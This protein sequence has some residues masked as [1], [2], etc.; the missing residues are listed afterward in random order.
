[1]LQVSNLNRLFLEHVSFDLARGERVALLGT[2]GSGKSLLLRAIADL[3]PNEGEVSLDG[4]PRASMPAPEW[5]HAVSYLANDAGWWAESVGEHFADPPAAAAIAG[6]LGLASETFA[7]P[8]TRLSSGEKQRLALIRVLV[9]EPSVLL[10]DEPTANLD[11]ETTES[12]ERLLEE[13]S[14]A[15]VAMLVVTHD[16]AQARR[17]AT[18]SL[19]LSNGCVV[20]EPA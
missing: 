3:D 6:R 12:V 8:I 9:Q 17:V 15:G 1:M 2:S 7:W 14:Q 5:R 4:R 16:Q 19:R 18:R 11:G 10:L 13:R 20:E